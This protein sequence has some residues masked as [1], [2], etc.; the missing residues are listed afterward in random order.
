MASFTYV[1]PDVDNKLCHP[2]TDKLSGKISQMSFC[3]GDVTVTLKSIGGFT[4]DI[5]FTEDE[6]QELFEFVTPYSSRKH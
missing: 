6:L 1:V 2:R 4:T 3:R 5:S